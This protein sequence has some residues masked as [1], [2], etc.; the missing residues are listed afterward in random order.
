MLLR[1]ANSKL[2]MRTRESVDKAA[3]NRGCGS[4]PVGEI[5]AHWRHLMSPHRIP[6][7]VSRWGAFCTSSVRYCPLAFTASKLQ[8]WMFVG[9]GADALKA[10]PYWGWEVPPALRCAGVHRTVTARYCFMPNTCAQATACIFSPRLSSQPWC[11]GVTV[12]WSA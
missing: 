4:L 11:G 7:T 9:Y 3:S 8:S 6:M 10:G 12:D 2:M 5:G 1:W